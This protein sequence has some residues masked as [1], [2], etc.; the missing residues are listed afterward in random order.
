LQLE[1]RKKNNE[2]LRFSLTGTEQTEE[3]ER[4]S[5]LLAKI[6]AEHNIESVTAIALSCEWEKIHL[7]M[8]RA[9]R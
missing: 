4:F 2:A 7:H 5:A 1:E 8:L 3:E 6:A 9:V